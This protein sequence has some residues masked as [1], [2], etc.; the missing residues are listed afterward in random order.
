LLFEFKVTAQNNRLYFLESHNKIWFPEYKG[1]IWIDAQTS[2][3]L[4]L[5]LQ[6]TDMPD[7]PTMR[8]K[9]EIDYSDL[10]L[11]DG[12]SMVLPT[13]SKALICSSGCA[14]SVTKFSNWHKFRAT[15]NMVVNP[16]N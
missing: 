10:L 7:Y 1:K 5:E 12:T 13:N 8:T 4:R 16:S 3:L 11:G 2:S 15:A 14:R 6:T 9:D